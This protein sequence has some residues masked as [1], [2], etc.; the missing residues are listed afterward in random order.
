MA[1][2]NVVGVTSRIPLDHPAS[3][4]KQIT[5]GNLENEIT[6]CCTGFYLSQW[7]VCTYDRYSRCSKY[8]LCLA[9]QQKCAL[10]LQT[11]VSVYLLTELIW[12]WN[13]IIRSTSTGNFE[14]NCAELEHNTNI[15]QQSS[16]MCRKSGS[17]SGVAIWSWRFL[18]LRNINNSRVKGNHLALRLRLHIPATSLQQVHSKITQYVKPQGMESQV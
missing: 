1:L 12:D 3:K 9:R 8:S 5:F 10:P 18:H 11:M 6:A 2:L 4:R 14:E 7:L 16:A 17:L 13:G 15:I